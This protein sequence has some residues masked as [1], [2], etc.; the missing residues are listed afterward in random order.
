MINASRVADWSRS[1]SFHTLRYTC[2]QISTE[3]FG[4]GTGVD[5][6]KRNSDG[7]CQLAIMTVWER[8]ELQPMSHVPERDIW[9]WA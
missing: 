4:I 9:A 7:L 5:R 8:G 2:V 3:A 1:D 6:G